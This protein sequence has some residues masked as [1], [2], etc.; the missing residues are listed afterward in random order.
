MAAAGQK[1]EAARELVIAFAR[2]ALGRDLG[3]DPSRESGS[4]RKGES[5][6]VPCQYR[7]PKAMQ[8]ASPNLLEVLFRQ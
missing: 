7:E 2:P 6:E 3:A 5:L 4:R 1:R 8:Y